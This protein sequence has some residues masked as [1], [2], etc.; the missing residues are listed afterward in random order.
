MTLEITDIQRAAVWPLS[1]ERFIKLF[2]VLSLILLT[3]R[4]T[5]HTVV[6][7]E[8]RM[9]Y[10]KEGW[11]LSFQQKTSQLRDAIYAVRP[12]LKGTNL[13]SRDFLDETRRYIAENFSMKNRGELLSITPMSMQY[14]GLNFEAEFFVEGLPKHPDHL[15]IATSGF[16]THEHSVKLLSITLGEQGYLNY[17]NSEQKQANFSF[18]A[19]RYVPLETDAQESNNYLISIIVFLTTIIIVPMALFKPSKL[20]F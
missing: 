14:G 5:A 6:L 12:D 19:R 4:T 18:N 17:F 9:N 20:E 8:Y 2:L 15:I 3:F 7:S 10:E 1:T 11:V 13:N 16:D